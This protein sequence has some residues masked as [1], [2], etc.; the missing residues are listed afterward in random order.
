VRSRRCGGH[1]APAQAFDLIH[2]DSVSSKEKDCAIPLE[3]DTYGST[4]APVA[5]GQ[6]VDGD[7]NVG[8]NYGTGFI[9]CGDD[10][11]EWFVG[12]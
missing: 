7:Y 2:G 11:R 3:P 10:Q 5:H 9:R 12:K 4:P 6:S 8:D 1:A